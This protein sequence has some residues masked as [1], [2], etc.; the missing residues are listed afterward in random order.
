MI[1]L[2]RV[3][4]LPTKHTTNVISTQ[5]YIRIIAFFLVLITCSRVDAQISLTD[6]LN[7]E[8]A[9]E[10]LVDKGIS[11][12]EVKIRLKAKGIDLD[13]LKPEQ[14]PTL[15]D[16]INEVLSEIESEQSDTPI[17]IENIASS[18]ENGVDTTEGKEDVVDVI[19]DIKEGSS[20]EEAL[21]ND[22]TK[23]LSEK[24][25]DK[26]NIFGH[27]IFFDQSIDMYNT[28]SSSTTPNSYVLDVGD[29]MAIN[30]FGTSQADFIYEIEDDG[31]IRPRG[32]Y[33][34]YLKGITIAK[35]KVLLRSRFRQAFIFSDGQFN[36]GLHTARTI[37][38]S[39]FGEVNQPGSYTISALNTALNAIV[40]AGG[41]TADAGIRNIRILS[42]GKERV[43]DVYDFVA[44]PKILYD[45]NL[46]DN[47]IIYISKWTKLVSA[48]GAGFKTNGRFELLENEG[49]DELLKYTQGLN[50][51]AY[52]NVV[53][54]K[55]TNGEEQVLK[56]FSIEEL[57]N[58]GVTLQ[59]GD[60]ITIKISSIAYENY[61]QI[62]GSVRHPGKYEFTKD[63]KVSDVLELAFLEEET[64]SE[65]AYLQRKNTDG[66]LQLIRLYIDNILTD[67]SSTD[68]LSL[69]K[70][71]VINVYS[72][73]SFVDNYFFNIEGAVR[74]PSKYFFDPEEN[75][76][77][78]DAIMLSKGVKVNATDF[79]YIV[80]SP[81]ENNLKRTYTVINI[82]E[83]MSDPDSKENVKLQARDKIIIPAI[84]QYED[85]YTVSISGA[86]RR[87]GSFVFD[88]SLSVKD[89]LILA[90][91]LK[92]QAATNKVDVFR[93]KIEDNVPTKT[94]GT[95]LILNRDLEPFDHSSD[96]VLQPYDH[97]V[98]RSSP[99]YEVIRYVN[100]NGEVRFPGLYAILE[101]NETISSLVKKAGG[102]TNEAFTEA[103][104][105]KRT[106]N[107]IG[108]IVTRVDKAIKGNTK[109]DVVLKQGDVIEIPKMLDIVKIDRF[110][111]NSN[112]VIKSKISKESDTTDALNLTVNYSKRRAN[113]FIN[114]FAGGFDRRVA[115][116][117]KTRVLHPNGQTSKTVSLG[118][119]KI[120]PRVRRGSEIVLIPCKAYLKSMEVKVNGVGQR[121]KLSLT[122]RLASLQ[123][124][125]TIVT[126]TVTTSITSFLL[127]KELSK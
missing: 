109:F 37:S 52:T 18:T 38:V 47:D 5:R 63:Q 65:L 20:L 84:E 8:Q 67:P 26:S 77:V 64:F 71:D 58:G 13:N 28:T 125:V 98:V 66:T 40:A 3:I 69:Q 82:K 74:K 10:D 83:I 89:M 22:L 122:E 101:D 78:Y 111:T 105:F 54:Y 114:Q 97:I 51:M 123:A 103:S 21:A 75:I 45:Y 57:K 35:A 41:I 44:N 106:Q 110:G 34:I 12:D 85:Q 53:Q 48:F 49:V 88:S 68:N 70:E 62:N 79:G 1:N 124:F 27:N 90:G 11:E 76:T 59:N 120:Y 29:K 112:K 4:P 95:T 6:N 19:E 102:L 55:T 92:L 15:Q 108:F 25:T 121:E 60:V 119:V 73:S 42:D 30:I 23:K 46:H 118:I 91:G 16:E 39:L 107:D 100:I 24:F 56:N 116:K 50:S 61:V 86:V 17:A 81:K 43:L 126:S 2:E 87:P 32:M 96:L 31:F 36:V 14:L 80:G 72:K 7:A 117:S 113:W 104:T 33:K 99:E 127:I 93:L 115:K 9:Q 94:Y